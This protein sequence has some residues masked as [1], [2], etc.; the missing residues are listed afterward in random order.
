M[1]S[2]L[3]CV[4]V[5]AVCAGLVAG[6]AFSKA[7]FVT[8]RREILSN[9]AKDNDLLTVETR[10]LG[11]VLNCPA[12]FFRTGRLLRDALADLR[13]RCAPTFTA[14]ANDAEHALR[15]VADEFGCPVTASAPALMVSCLKSKGAKWRAKAIKFK[16]RWEAW[17]A[18]ERAYFA[19]LV[20]EGL[21]PMTSHVRPKD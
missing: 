1:K 2:L 9:T 10:L 12:D 7:M 11:Q 15:V 17:V 6:F 19:N 14:R 8:E 4:A 16:T 5:V 20:R 3:A 21:V 18:Q 13:L